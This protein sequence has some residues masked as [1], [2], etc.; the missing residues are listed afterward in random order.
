ML[1][2]ELQDKFAVPPET[3]WRT[4]A[5]VLRQKEFVAYQIAEARQSNSADLGPEFKWKEQGVLLG[6]RYDCECSI[7]GWEPPEWLCFG[8]KNLFHVS[9]E[10]SASENGTSVVYRCELPQTP[11]SRRDAIEEICRQSLI[12]LKRHLEGGRPAGG[13]WQI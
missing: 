13:S 12:N 9:Y 4:I 3:A 6:R 5:D 2:I 10:L 7:F 1:T 11:E 8:T